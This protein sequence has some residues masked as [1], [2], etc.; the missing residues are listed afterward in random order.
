MTLEMQQA[1]ST[2]YT[3]NP[4]TPP[5]HTTHTHTPSLPLSLL[6]LSLSHTHTHMHSIK[7]A[8]T[9]GI[10]F[11]LAHLG[12]QTAQGIGL[13]VTDIAT[14]WVYITSKD[15]FHK[16]L[17]ALL[18]KCPMQKSPELHEGK[19]ISRRNRRW[20]VHYQ[21]TQVVLEMMIRRILI[22]LT[23]RID[24]SIVRMISLSYLQKSGATN[25]SFIECI[26]LYRVLH[27]LGFTVVFET[28][29]ERFHRSLWI[30]S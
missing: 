10:G 15:F 6:C 16:A 3:R 27:P 11:F 2:V 17:W 13:V 9:A 25:S 28:S 26:P 22:L 18:E 1:V 5:T 7:T 8:T 29:K 30:K 20:W 12:L 24:F 19:G 21:K 4:H 23:R 14:G